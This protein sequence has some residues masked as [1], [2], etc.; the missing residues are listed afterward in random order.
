M[1]DQFER[2]RKE[3]E[4]LKLDPQQSADYILKNQNAMREER[5]KEEEMS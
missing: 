5:L 2:L 1:G 4:S 3:A